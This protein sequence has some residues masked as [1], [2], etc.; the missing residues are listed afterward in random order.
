MQM[1]CQESRHSLFHRA[2]ELFHLFIDIYHCHNHSSDLASDSL[3]DSQFSDAFDALHKLYDNDELDQCIAGAESLL[4]NNALP[5]YHRI[6]T[7]LL[8]ASTVGDRSDA[9]GYR[10]Q[11]ELLWRIVRRWNPEGEDDKVDEALAET[12][13]TLDEVKGV[14]A[15]ERVE[16]DELDAKL[17][18]EQDALMV[19]Y[20]ERIAEEQAEAMADYDDPAK[21]EIAD[22][23]LKDSDLTE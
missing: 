6:K 15:G 19:E 10:S 9:E 14:L 8:L 3:I 4:Q 17:E 16:E 11:A 12:R 18:A 2:N 23:E 22:H 20:D 13:I 21:L 1:L 5:R 7:L